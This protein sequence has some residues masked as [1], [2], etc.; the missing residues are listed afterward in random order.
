MIMSNENYLRSVLNSQEVKPG[1]PEMK[2]LEIARAEIQMLIE[3]RFATSKPSIRYGGSKA[4]G[5]MI[6]ADYD[7]DIISYFRHE[8]TDAGK[9]IPEIYNNMHT[10]LASRYVVEPRT[11]A[12]RV[13]AQ[14]KRDLHIDV[15]PGRFIDGTNTIAY[16][17]QNGGPKGYLKTN[18]QV[19]IDHVKG[20]GCTDFIQLAKLWK[21]ENGV[22]IRTFPLELAVIEALK[23]QR[24]QGLSDRFEHVLA[25]FATGIDKI[26]IE[27][28]ANPTGNDL[29]DVF[30][31]AIRGRLSRVAQDT[32]R[33]ASR[34]GWEGVFTL[35]EVTSD[36]I[37]RVTVLRQAVQES[38]H[39][40]G[41][42]CEG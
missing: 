41:P 42:W 25:T 30:D 22:G 24:K 9:T 32:L 19:H 35:S 34:S 8:D 7:L 21:I 11:T 3:S 16:L 27:D 28:P 17:H 15:V 39:R 23:G 29:S 20:S 26:H 38:T 36:A 2:A 33:T 12:L 6:L 37:P 4:K 40:A 31:D 10:A 18:I 13:K 14:D 5:T 1:S